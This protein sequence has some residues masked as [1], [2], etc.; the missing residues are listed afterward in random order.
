MRSERQK[1]EPAQRNDPRTVTVDEASAFSRRYVVR[2]ALVIAV[3]GGAVYAVLRQSLVSGL[4]LTGAGVVVIIN[5]RWLDAILA[6]VVQPGRPRFDL[7]SVLGIFG[8]FALLGVLLTALIWVPPI[9]EIGVA[10]GVSTL[11]VAVIFEGLRWKEDGG[12]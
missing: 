11:V 1:P 3:V 4:S 8:R 5:Y 6:S 7:R 12:G 10:L 9:D 2:T